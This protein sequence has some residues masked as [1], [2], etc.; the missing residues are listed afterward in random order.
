MSHDTQ[1]VEPSIGDLAQRLEGM[2]MVLLF[3]AVMLVVVVGLMV[4]VIAAS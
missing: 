3:I 4:V 2:R 1:V